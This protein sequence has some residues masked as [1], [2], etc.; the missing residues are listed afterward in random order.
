MDDLSQLIQD[1]K[2]SSDYYT[3][4]EGLITE[5]Q[6]FEAIEALGNR[7]FAIKAEIQ[8]KLDAGVDP[9]DQQLQAMVIAGQQIHQM[10][11]QVVNDVCARFEVIHPEFANPDADLLRLKRPYWDWYRD[12]YQKYYHRPAPDIVE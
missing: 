7:I 5:V 10:Q 6:C 8:K 9:N 4:R 2:E 11:A 1:R 3:V 12:M